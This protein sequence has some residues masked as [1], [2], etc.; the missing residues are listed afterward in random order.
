MP[1]KTK[2]EKSHK[3]LVSHIVEN[4]RSVLNVANVGLFSQICSVKLPKEGK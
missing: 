3:I 4:I 2:I 1:Y